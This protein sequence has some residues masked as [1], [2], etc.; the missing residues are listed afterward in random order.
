MGSINGLFFRVLLRLTNNL[1]PVHTPNAVKKIRKLSA[2]QLN[3]KVPDGYVSLKESTP[4]GTKYE[5]VTKKGASGNGKAIYYLH[6]GAYISGLLSFYRN[7]ANDFFEASGGCELILLDYKLAPEYT[8]PT[9]LNEAVDVWNHLT[10]NLGYDAEKII[11]GGDS[12]GANLTLALMLKLRDDGKKMPK[13]GFCISLWGDMTGQGD[14][15]SYNY[16]ND[17]MFGE[18]GKELTPAARER[19]IHSEIYS[20]LGSVDRTDPY[21]S[22]VYGEYHGFPPMFFTAGGHEMLLSDTLTV[23]D[24]LKADGIYSGYDVQPK[25]FHIY[26]IYGGYLPEG[27]VSYN[28]ILSFIHDQ[29]EATR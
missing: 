23:I 11:I 6:G 14:S 22:P 26:A 12:A 10:Q 2:S 16:R 19:L 4:S 18:K 13:A 7:F 17:V 24:K 21:V 25:M 9:Q 20:Y 3:D 28:K 29:F 15:F 8:Y 5:R 1:N 27:K